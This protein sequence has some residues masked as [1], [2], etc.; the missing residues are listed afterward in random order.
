MAFVTRFDT[1]GRLRDAPAASPFYES[2]HE[3]VAGIIRPRAPGRASRSF[4][5]PSGTDFEPAAALAYP[6]IGF[7]RPHLLINHRDDRAAAFGAGENRDAQHEYLEWHVTRI[8]GKIS[9]VVFVTETPEYWATLAAHAPERVLELY[10]ELVDPAVALEDLFADDGKYDPRNQWNSRRGI[11]HYIMSINSLSALINAQRDS[12]IS[13]TSLDNYDGLPLRFDPDNEISTASDARFSLDIGA[14]SRRGFAVTVG[15]P[16]GLYMVAWDDA[17]WTKPDGTP[18]G[19]YWRVRRGTPDAALRL[20]YE[21]PA[22]EG[23]V[24]GDI[25]IGGRPIEYGGQLAEHITVTAGGL[26]GRVR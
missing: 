8:D 10:R 20:E 16:V 7:P 2:W 22:G 4:F 3:R 5:D 26:V 24:V 17:G 23:F 12:V 25:R 14:C 19:D 11:V 9:R 1:P 18:V 13:P 6:W 15:E 21:V